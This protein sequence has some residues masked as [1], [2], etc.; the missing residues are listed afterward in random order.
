MSKA[1]LDD[2]TWRGSIAQSTDRAELEKYLSSP[3]A[4][5]YL[6]FDPT[7]PSLHIGNLVALTLLRRFQLAGYKPIALVGGATGLVGDPSGRSAERS[8]NE[9][10]LVADWVD[11]I[12]K[13][14]EGFLDFT[15]K[16]AAIMA[17]NLD[18]TAPVSAIE[19][20]RDIGKH[21]SVNQMLAKDSFLQIQEKY[22]CFLKWPHRFFHRRHMH[23]VLRVIQM[24]ARF[25]IK[26]LPQVF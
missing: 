18:W 7:A 16:N 11:R 13:Q 4:S 2:L 26:K 6:G 14:L 17:N 19:F 23:N 3:G 12:R 8:L 10:D 9:A 15:G 24:F 22:L 25:P 20:L 5:L 1:L 21:F